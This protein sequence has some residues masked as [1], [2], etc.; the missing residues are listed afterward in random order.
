MSAIAAAVSPVVMISANAILIGGI[1]AKHEAMAGRL[2]TLTAEWRSPAT[3]PARRT[4][5]RAQVLLF[6]ERFLW[7][8]RAHIALYVATACFISVVITIAVTSVLEREPRTA[9]PLLL[10]GM[11]L[12]LAA[13]FLELLDLRKA[14]A[15]ILIESSDLLR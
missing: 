1:S 12:T 15:T 14:H 11:G 3:E 6:E 8:T 10:T 7:I 5:I 13:I 2:R 9:L 4:M